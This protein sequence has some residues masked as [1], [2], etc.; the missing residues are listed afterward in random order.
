MEP[1]FQ[2]VGSLVASRPAVEAIDQFVQAARRERAAVMAKS[3]Q[4]AT[5]VRFHATDLRLVALACRTLRASPGLPLRF[6]FSLASREPGGERAGDDGMAIGAR[7]LEQAQSL[8]AAARDGQLLV[9]PALC[10]LLV[11]AGYR[12]ASCPLRRR[13]AEPLAAF[14]VDLEGPGQGEAAAP[15]APAADE[16]APAAQPAVDALQSL[17]VQVSEMARRQVDLEWR[18]QQLLGRLGRVDAARVP[19]RS[20]ERLLDELDLQMGRIEARLGVIDGAERRLEDLQVSLQAVERA[21]AAQQPRLSE[22]DELRRRLDALAAPLAEAERSSAAL[23][24]LRQQA[25]ELAGRAAETARLI[26]DIEQRRQGVEQVQARAATV[27]HLLGDIEL[28]LERVSEQR[29]MVDLA[30]DRLARLDFT[31]Q[32]A[33]S[34]LHALQRERDV[35]ERIE[36]SLKASRAR[37]PRSDPARPAT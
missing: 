30:G 31:M 36:Q 11:E 8:A 18:Q 1:I 24:A 27:T 22:V 10:G 35:A 23:A 16:F 26:D 29:A 20:W 4:G 28:Q 5:L 6:A 17:A 37:A 21:L 2:L 32:E 14:V 19:G 13:G 25:D 34:L 15:A 3:A 7:S 33:H 9:A 12:L